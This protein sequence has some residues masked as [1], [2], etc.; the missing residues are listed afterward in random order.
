[1]IKNVTYVMVSISVVPDKDHV[2]EV[3]H[4]D[5]RSNN[6]SVVQFVVVAHPGSDESPEGLHCWISSESGNFLWL[7]SYNK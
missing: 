1:V 7:S 4:S 2:P 3:V 6:I 5:G